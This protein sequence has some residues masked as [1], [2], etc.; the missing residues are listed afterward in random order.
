MNTWKFDDSDDDGFR[1]G[2]IDLKKDSYKSKFIIQERRVQRSSKQ[3][4]N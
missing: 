1:D 2:D 3:I 4:Q